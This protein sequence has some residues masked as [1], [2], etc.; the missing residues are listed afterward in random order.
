MTKINRSH[1]RG[2]IIISLEASV[3]WPQAFVTVF[4]GA[5]SY[6]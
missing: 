3:L 6:F 1:A 2:D 5:I 4:V